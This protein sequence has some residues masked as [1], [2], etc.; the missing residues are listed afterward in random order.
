MDA[1]N[2]LKPA[3]ARGDFQCIGAT[4]ISEYRRY[5]EED[6]A[7]ERR[8]QPVIVP[9]PSVEETIQILFGLRERYEGFHKLK[10]SDGAIR[11]AAT[12]SDQYIAD[13]FLPDKAILLSA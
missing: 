5:I 8:F 2:I 13:R 7:L 11:A 4:T 3:L 1:A 10:I 9:E 6:P 12:L